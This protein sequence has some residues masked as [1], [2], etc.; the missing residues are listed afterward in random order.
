MHKVMYIDTET[1][2]FDPSKHGLTEVGAIVVEKYH[3][4]LDWT[5]LYIN[6][7]TYKD[8]KEVTEEALK[9]CGKKPCELMNYPHQKEAFEKFYSFCKDR[10]K[11]EKIQLIGYNTDFDID[12]LK[13]WFEENDEDFYSIFSH[14]TLDVLDLV[15]QLQYRGLIQTENAKL[16]TLCKWFDIDI[17]AHTAIGDAMATLKLHNALFEQYITE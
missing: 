6:P 12:F 8:D 16:T 10:A 7:H 17:D 11:E 13:A 2:G 5:N 15:R 4:V 3:H 14:R 9:L 1:T